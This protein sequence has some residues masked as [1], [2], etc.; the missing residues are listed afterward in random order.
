[1]KNLM[2]KSILKGVSYPA[3]KNLIEDLLSEGKST[4]KVQSSSL[5]NYSLSNHTRMKRLDKTIEL[6]KEM[7]AIAKEVSES[8]TWVVITESW[9]VDAA[10]TMPVIYKIASE[11]DKINFTVVLRSENEELMNKFLTNGTKSIPIIIAVNSENKVINSWG[12][13]PSKALEMAKNHKKKYGTLDAVFKE[14]LGSWYAE[15]KGK[16]IQRDFALL[17]K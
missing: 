15:D 8:Q 2:K 4:G 10:Q 14:D 11:N 7:L 1:M 3:Y 17:L 16:N 9:C 12:P 6:S 5:L 13:R